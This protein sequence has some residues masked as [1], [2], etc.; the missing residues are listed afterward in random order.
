MN[1][2]LSRAITACVS[3]LSMSVAA[4]ATVQEADGLAGSNWM[5]TPSA[6]TVFLAIEFPEDPAE[7]VAVTMPALLGMRR[8]MVF[9]GTGLRPILTLE[10]GT[11]SVRIELQR[12]GERLDARLEARGDGDAS[13]EMTFSLSPWAAP[14]TLP[15]SGVYSGRLDLP[16]G[17]KLEMIL[18]LG[19][20][21][22]AASAAISIPAQMIESYPAAAS[23][24]DGTWT[25]EANFGTMVRIDLVTTG[26]G[27]GLDGTMTQSGFEM[28][29]ALKKLTEDEVAADPRPQTPKPPFPYS[30]VEARIPAPGGHELAGTLL[31][32]DGVEQPPVAVLVTGSGPQDRDES[33]MGH[34]PFLVLADALA[35]RGIA[36][37]RCDDRG[38]GD[39]TG[40]HAS[41]VTM[42]FADDALAAVDW[43]RKRD[44]VDH[45]LIGIIG[46]SEGGLVAPIAI[47]RDPDIAF[48]V[49]MAG[50]GVDGGRILTSQTE[51]MLEVGGMDRERIDGII[52]LHGELMDAVRSD[53]T[54]E[55]IRRRYTGLSIAQVEAGRSSVGDEATDQM[56]EATLQQ[57]EGS[58]ELFNDW[59]VAFIKIDPRAYLSRMRCPV[60]ALNGTNDV[61][62]LS[63]LNLPEIERAVTTGGGQVTV[64][65][66]EGVN[67]LFQR[68]ETGAVQ[69]YASIRTTIEPEVL[70]DIIDWIH[71]ISDGS[72]TGRKD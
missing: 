52:T 16:G 44:D 63:E 3:G 2:I 29:L 57:I 62:V 32:P 41:A 38:V 34:K 71:A 42:D 56:L 64:S 6:D 20:S 48:A 5:V 39:S 67:H 60:L 53:A 30:V 12:E 9:G 24:A 66:D 35:R 65:E 10:D 18:E 19:H 7:E 28:A 15:S 13:R 55:E 25:I 47:S 33:L 54:E 31:L 72:R 1:R 36:S 26:E 37:L 45:G 23:H 59:L 4:V 69:E 70:E 21:A 49:L 50:T 58:E 17:G 46:H 8:P 68:S 27:G 11:A 61:Q 43:L 14:G 40:D 22:E 51:R